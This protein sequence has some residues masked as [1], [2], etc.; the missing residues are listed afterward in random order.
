MTRYTKVGQSKQEHDATNWED[1][2]NK[3]KVCTNCSV[4][5]LT[6]NCMQLSYALSFFNYFF[7][8][9]RISCL[10]DMT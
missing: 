1:L 7:Y 10:N 4:P 6:Q 3:E 5:I 8:I 2:K 9:T